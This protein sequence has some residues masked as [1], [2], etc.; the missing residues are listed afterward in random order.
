MKFFCPKRL[1]LQTQERDCPRI[2][3]PYQD[4]WC[5]TIDVLATIMIEPGNY[6]RTSTIVI[7]PGQRYGWRRVYIR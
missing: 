5:E 3:V 2:S 4:G 7:E 6:R 1:S